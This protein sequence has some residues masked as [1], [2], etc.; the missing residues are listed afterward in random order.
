MSKCVLSPPQTEQGVSVSMSTTWW[1]VLS[2]D[3]RQRENQ[4]SC[5]NRTKPDRT[6]PDQTSALFWYWDRSPFMS[7]VNIVLMSISTAAAAHCA[8]IHFQLAGWKNEA[9]FTLPARSPSVSSSSSWVSR[10]PGS[11]TLDLVLV[12]GHI[13]RLRRSTPTHRRVRFLLGLFRLRLL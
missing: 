8:E 5:W 10:R 6:K 4:Y 9:P 3:G 11:H 1:S 12:K 13:H 7:I 2:E